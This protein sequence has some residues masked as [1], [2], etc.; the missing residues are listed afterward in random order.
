MPL[1]PELKV[2]IN[3]EAPGKLSYMSSGFPMLE[4]EAG[5]SSGYVEFFKPF[6]YYFLSIDYFAGAGSGAVLGDKIS[7]EVDNDRDLTTLVGAGGQLLSDEAAGDDVIAVVPAIIQAGILHLGYHLKFASAS[8]EEYQV[9]AI[10]DASAGTVQLDRNLENAYTAG[11]KIFRTI[12]LGR[13]IPVMP[14]ANPVV[15]GESKVGAS[16]L[17]AGWKFRVTYEAADT[18]GRTIA[19]AIEGSVKQE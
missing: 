19:V 17:P 9:I 11:D 8:N 7:S 3:E 4:I 16:R 18:D 1:I 15:F 10:L 6:D 13:D 12:E 5:Q 14:A 2:E